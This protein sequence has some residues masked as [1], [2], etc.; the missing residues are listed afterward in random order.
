LREHR[1]VT[2]GNEFLLSS[3]RA[4]TS[5][6]VSTSKSTLRTAVALGSLSAGRYATSAHDSNEGAHAGVISHWEETAV[7]RDTIDELREQ[8]HMHA[9]HGEP[10]LSPV[11][12]A[13]LNR[14]GFEWLLKTQHVFASPLTGSPAGGW[15]AGDAAGAEPNSIATAAVLIALKPFYEAGTVA[16]TK[17]QIEQAASAGV[18]WLLHVQNDDGGWPTFGGDSES[19]IDPT[20]YAMR[21]L[22]TWQPVLE[23]AKCSA[24]VLRGV[25]FL[26]S[27]QRED[28]SFVPQWFGNV[29]QRE[30]EN[31][32]IGT[33]LVLAACA[34]VHQLDSTMAQRAASWL[35]G[36]QHSCGGWGP[37]R[38]PVDYSED[39]RDENFRSW[40]EN[41]RLAK[42]CSV[43]ETS[44]A[45]SA[46][47][48]LA[49][50][51]AACE[52]SVTRGVSWLADV[53]EHDGHRKPAIV[54]FY[55]WRIWYYERLYPLALAAGAL[56]RAVAALAPAAAAETSLNSR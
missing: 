43:E 17:H 12:E 47:L 21:A 24:A 1:I 25:S 39:D 33:S 52:R 40:R 49:A 29:H 30:H 15:G 11:E 32:V 36:A 51:N 7:P 31:P 20:T 23:S 48:P 50:T 27:S 28:G 38:V 45:V 9:G 10:Q 2:R 35:A 34:E 5:W 6:A 3:V 44:A 54:G 14:R 16:E 13:A 37:P 41:D 46:L 26:E 55:F 53:V 18:R 4:D 56:S 8:L 19:T 42:Y 22:A